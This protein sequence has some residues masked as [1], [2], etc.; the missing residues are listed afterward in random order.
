MG[1]AAWSGIIIPLVIIAVLLIVI[2]AAII[3]IKTKMQKFSM[4][5]F[6]TRDFFK[7]MN[8]ANKKLSETPKT[9][10][11][12]TS[13]Y[14]PEII[15]DFPEF[16][17]DL[18][19]EKAKGVLRGYFNAIESKHASTVGPECSA[20]LINHIQGIIEDLN[21]RG[22]DQHFNEVVIHSME[23]SR[24][25]KNG[26]TVDLVFSSAVGLYDYITDDKGKVVFGSEDRKKQTIYTV[27]LVYVQDEDKMAES[28]ETSAIGVH[29]PNCGA[30]VKTI[31]QKFCEYCGSGILEINTRS[32]KFDAVHEETRLKTAY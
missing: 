10:R 13:I 4:E 2:V 18:Y 11:S 14:K 9:V 12:M 22:Y 6:G 30:P 27:E 21:S 28:S 26:A 15:R 20:A 16:D 7:G 5:A 1:A 3:F 23:L 17:Y 8:E 29:C 31:G 32:W 25:I 19:V 24:Y